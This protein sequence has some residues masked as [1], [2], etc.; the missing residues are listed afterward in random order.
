MCCLGL[1]FVADVAGSVSLVCA[2][3]GSA[4]TPMRRTV[5]QHATV[6]FVVALL[7]TAAVLVGYRCK[8]R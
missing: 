5:Q 6:V 8:L 7:L 2:S 3:G 1:V 4:P